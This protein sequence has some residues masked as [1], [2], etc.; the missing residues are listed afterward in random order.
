MWF[1]FVRVG[2]DEFNKLACHRL[3]VPTPSLEVPRVGRDF[4]CQRTWNSCVALF[5]ASHSSF[6]EYGF[7]DWRMEAL[8]SWRRMDV[9]QLDSEQ[10]S[11]SPYF[12]IWFFSLD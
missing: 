6:V 9:C 2:A 4:D 12:K 3:L 8:V 11:V 7:L 1:R 10:S 5:R